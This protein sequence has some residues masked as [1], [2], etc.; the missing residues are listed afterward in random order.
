MILDKFDGWAKNGQIDIMN[1]IEDN[2]LGASIHYRRNPV[3][4]EFNTLRAL[5]G[6]NDFQTPSFESNE[7]D[8]GPFG[9]L[10]FRF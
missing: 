2:K 1:N 6:L 9:G 3:Q 10:P 4:N 8:K 5:S 7:S